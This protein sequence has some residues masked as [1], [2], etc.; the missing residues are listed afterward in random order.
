MILQ[1][2]ALVQGLRHC[3]L[4]HAHVRCSWRKWCDCHR[5]VWLVWKCNSSLGHDSKGKASLILPQAGWQSL[6]CMACEV[7]S[8]QMHLPGDLLSDIPH[9]GLY[10]QRGITTKPWSLSHCGWPFFI[11]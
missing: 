2:V 4:A 5:G 11:A 7:S 1:N 9:S 10:R 3:L 6:M 8:R